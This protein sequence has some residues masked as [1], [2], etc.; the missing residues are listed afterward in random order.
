MI[1]IRS[2]I[3]RQ[4]GHVTLTEPLHLCL[5]LVEGVEVAPSHGTP[6]V[7]PRQRVR[8]Y[9]VESQSLDQSPVD[10][11]AQVEG[12]LVRSERARILNSK[13]PVHAY[14]AGIVHPGHTKLDEPFR[15]HQ[16]LRHEG[17]PG[18]PVEQRAET[19]HRAGDGFDV[20]DLVRVA[21]VR[22]G[23]EESGRLEAGLEA[24]VALPAEERLVAP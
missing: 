16:L 2:H 7:V 9:V 15:F 12:T 17:V 14:H 24:N 21:A 18:V 6:H 5:R 3:L 1:D 23:D 22:L 10:V 11:R 8:E 13:S 20:F 4:L 19:F